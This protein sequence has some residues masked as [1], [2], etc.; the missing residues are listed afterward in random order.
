MKK[1]KELNS[2]NLS[3]K[4]RSG[5][6]NARTLAGHHACASHILPDHPPPSCCQ[7]LVDA[8]FRGTPESAKVIAS[9]RV[10]SKLVTKS[11][12]GS[13]ERLL[14][15]MNECPIYPQ[16]LNKTEHRDGGFQKAAKRIPLDKL[17]FQYFLG[18][19]FATETLGRLLHPGDK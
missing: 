14:P 12:A 16:N 7:D 9:Q 4:S 18:C 15:V 6:Q 17:K 13:P 10:L 2:K 3:S 19:L 11:Q 1:K 5:T 8:R